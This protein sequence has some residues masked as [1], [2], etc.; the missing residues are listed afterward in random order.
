MND[1]RVGGEGLEDKAG[2]V[3]GGEFEGEEF[4]GEEFKS[5]MVG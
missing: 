2:L 4:K 1:E 5:I 3:G